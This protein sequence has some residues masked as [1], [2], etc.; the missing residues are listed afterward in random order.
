MCWFK[1]KKEYLEILNKISLINY[2]VALD[3]NTNSIT[4]PPTR[5]L[6]KQII[7]G[8]S[9]L[10]QWLRV[11]LP[12]DLLEDPTRHRATKPMQHSYWA[13]ALQLLKPKYP[14]ACASQQEKLL[15]WETR[16]LQL[17]SSPCSPQQLLFCMQQWRSSVS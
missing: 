10:V 15:K 3:Y 7:M 12:M 14:R 11:H 6:K 9:L 17:E 5:K 16:A 4:S 2:E 8:T 1:R 13:H